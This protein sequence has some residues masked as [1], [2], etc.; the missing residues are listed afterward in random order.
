V[1]KSKG[2]RRTQIRLID[3]I[4][5]D[6]SHHNHLNKSAFL[7]FNRILRIIFFSFH[8]PF[9]FVTVLSFITYQERLRDMALRSLDNLLLPVQ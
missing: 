1:E 6:K 7:S 9:I 5:T 2:K 4:K 8:F 3:L